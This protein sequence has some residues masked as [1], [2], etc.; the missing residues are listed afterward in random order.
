MESGEPKQGR[1][2]HAEDGEANR[3]TLLARLRDAEQ[4]LR[5]TFTAAARVLWQQ[6][7]DAEK[8]DKMQAQ[9]TGQ[10]HTYSGLIA[11]M[12]VDQ[13]SDAGTLQLS[14]MIDL[15]RDETIQNLDALQS[16]SF[17]LNHMSSTET[18]GMG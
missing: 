6:G 3:Q 1:E 16:N 18:V 9:C 8:V 11:S 12:D 10:L 15:Y 13:F 5:T 4:A 7:V 14:H 2:C 17:K